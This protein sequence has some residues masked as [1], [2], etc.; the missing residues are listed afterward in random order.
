MVAKSGRFQTAVGGALALALVLM[1][2]GFML[3]AGAC[4]NESLAG[5]GPDPAL[6]A[7]PVLPAVTDGGKGDGEMAA[8]AGE[9]SGDEGETGGTVIAMESALIDRELK[10]LA[11]GDPAPDFSYTLA[12]GTTHTLSGHQGTKVMINFWATW[13]P[14]CKAEM[15]DIQRAFEQYKGDG[16]VVLAV[17]QDPE[18]RLI[19]PFVRQHGL[20]FPVIAD[21]SN[22][23]AQRYGAR[24]LPSSYFVNA[25][26][27]LHAK[28]LGMMSVDLIGKRLAEMP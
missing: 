24:G 6:P 7:T 11:K 1:M 9:T 10:P 23:I 27:T 4:G 19:A 17:S 12:D 16:F 26:G 5:P 20:T 13:C 21:P 15:P 25:D 3:L 22:E 18:T 8:G 28:V 2:I 14:P